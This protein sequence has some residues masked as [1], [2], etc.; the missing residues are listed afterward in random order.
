MLRLHTAISSATHS[1]SLSPLPS[2]WDGGETWGKKKSKTLFL[3]QPIFAKTEKEERSKSNDNL[4]YDCIYMCVYTYT[5]SHT[6]AYTHI[7]SI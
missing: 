5:Y 4:I 1:L 6:H 2:Q 3:D 7:C